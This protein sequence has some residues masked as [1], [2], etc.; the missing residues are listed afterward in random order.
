MP[1]E[2]ETVKWEHALSICGPSLVWMVISISIFESWWIIYGLTDTMN[3]EL[4]DTCPPIL[5]AAL[6]G[7]YVR[8]THKPSGC[9]GQHSLVEGSVFRST[10]FNSFLRRCIIYGVAV[11]F[12][13][14]CSPK[15]RHLLCKRMPLIIH[16]HLRFE[17]LVCV[18]YVSFSLAHCSGPHW[19]KTRS[20]YFFSLPDNT[21]KSSCK[22]ALDSAQKPIFGFS[23]G[24]FQTPLVTAL[25][26][27]CL[28]EIL[29]PSM[30]LIDICNTFTFPSY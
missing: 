17:E 5:C 24:F 4:K 27:Q 23:L 11:S 25:H 7:V 21:V 15:K 13:T 10:L 1:D 12:R 26:L 20:L 8:D 19:L 6:K 2:R 14:T 22:G 9:N 18:A 16:D 30:W 29:L 3:A 28:F